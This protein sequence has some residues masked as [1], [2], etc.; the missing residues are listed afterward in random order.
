[1]K[2]SKMGKSFDHFYVVLSMNKLHRQS[3]YF[4]IFVF[5]L[6]LYPNSESENLIDAS[7]RLSAREK[8]TCQPPP[9]VPS[10][11][12]TCY[13]FLFNGKYS[14]I[15]PTIHIHPRIDSSFLNTKATTTTTILFSIR[16]KKLKPPSY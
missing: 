4:F 16:I 9:H 3:R 10:K 12:L 15:Y 8:S 2:G 11:Y 7:S 13:K 1:M 14:S 5:L 6:L